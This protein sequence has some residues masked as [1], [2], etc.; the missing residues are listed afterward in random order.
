MAKISDL[1]RI[2]ELSGKE[3]FPLAVSGSNRGVEADALKEYFRD[4]SL[5]IFDGFVND[6]VTVLD[7]T[8]DTSSGNIRIVYLTVIGRFVMEKT[9]EGYAPSYYKDFSRVGDFMTGDIVRADRVFFN[10]EDKELYVYNGSLHNLFDTVRI[11]AMT[12][13]EFENLTNPIEGA[14]YATFE[15]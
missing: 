3:V 4:S 10:I 7:G 2:A 11:N 12:E 14:F 13:E 6:S 15:E 8:A 1:T 9:M 5:A